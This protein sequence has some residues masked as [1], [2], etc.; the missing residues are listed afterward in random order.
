[1]SLLENSLS[2]MELKNHREKD[3]IIAENKELRK[4]IQHL[5]EMS[6]SLERQLRTIF[7]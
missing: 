2:R 6:E 1:M 5:E 4:K 3:A 7:L